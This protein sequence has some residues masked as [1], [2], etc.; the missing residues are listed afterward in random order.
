MVDIKISKSFNYLNISA[1]GPL[2][3]DDVIELFN[4]IVVSPDF[5]YGIDSIVDLSNAIVDVSVPDME[6][7]IKHS[8]KVLKE[9]E[10]GF[11]SA[12]IVTDDLE[13]AMVD[14]FNALRPPGLASQ[15]RVFNDREQAL[16]WI[17]S[18]D[19]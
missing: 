17:A 12:L 1:S 11:K 16:A 13:E 2:T 7:I 4:Q 15:M 14:L 3:V 6:R 9:D 10:F 19:E 18:K 5:E 8:T